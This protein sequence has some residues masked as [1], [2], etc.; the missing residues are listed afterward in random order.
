MLD[1]ARTLGEIRTVVDIGANQG[2][3]AIAARKWF[4][5]AV[6]HAYEPNT[7][8][9]DVLE[10]NAGAVEAKVFWEAVGS[11]PGT[12]EL[13]L[14]DDT[15]LTRAHRSDQGAFPLVPFAT[16]AERIGGTID[17]LKLDCEGW[18]WEIL[19]A[20]A[21]RNVRILTMEYHLAETS[22]THDDVGP[23]LAKRAFSLLKQRRLSDFGQ[24][25]GI[26]CSS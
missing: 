3:F 17:L 13:E 9:H 14:F 21:V 18:E 10:S 11:T 1:L 16:V 19:E 5:N 15:N 22:L 26:R 7:A 2:F 8:L 23:W 20:A 6:I 4:P 25:L 12:V 24:V